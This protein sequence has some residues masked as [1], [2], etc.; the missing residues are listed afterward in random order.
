MIYQITSTIG[1]SVGFITIATSEMRL[2]GES[3]I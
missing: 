3:S 1:N 2:D